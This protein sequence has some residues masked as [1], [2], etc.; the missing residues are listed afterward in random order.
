M[1]LYL[2]PELALTLLIMTPPAP[3]SPPAPPAP[4][5]EAAVP[6]VASPPLPPIAPSPPRVRLKIPTLPSPTLAK[7]FGP[8]MTGD[9]M[10]IARTAAEAV[11]KSVRLVM[12]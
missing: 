6:V 7:S 2:L 8:A 3:P 4:P 10:T 1:R 12:I 5:F 9:A 11:V